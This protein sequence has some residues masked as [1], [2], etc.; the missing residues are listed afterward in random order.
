ML[1]LLTLALTGILFYWIPK[2]FF[3]VQNTGIIQGISEA[4]PK[5]S[6]AAMVKRQQDIVKVI[7]QDP[8]VENVTSF[9]GTDG[10]NTALNRGRIQIML[11]EVNGEYVNSMKVIQRLEEKLKQV[12]G[13]KLY[14][15]PVQDI[16]IEDRISPRQYQYS[17][18][19]HEDKEVSVLSNKLV[20]Q[21]QT[22]PALKDVV[23]D[24]QEDGLQT[25]ITIDRDSA[26]RFGITPQMIDNILYDSFSQR[27]ISTIF[28][29]LNQYHVI[30]ELQ[31]NLQESVNAFDDLYLRSANGD[32]VPINNFIKV[33]QSTRSNV[34]Y[35]QG[36]FPVANLSFN[37]AEKTALGDATHLIEQAEKSINLPLHISTS[38][39]GVAK[40]F[41]SSFAN[42]VWLILASIIIVYIVLGILYES[43]IHPFT[44]LS[45]LPSAGL[46]VLLALILLGHEFNIIALI[47]TILL[48]GIVMKNAIMMID[49]ALE[50]E[51]IQNK[52]AKEAI[53][54]ACLL[55]LRP[56][57]M[58]T[59]SAM[60]GAVPL[61]F[62]AGIGSEIRE[63]LG[64]AIIGGLIL[65]QLLTLYTTPVVYLAF[66]KLAKIMSSS[67]LC[68]RR[69]SDQSSNEEKLL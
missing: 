28:T 58:T 19:G 46:G 33:T 57:L 51:R 44:I 8:A 15:Q 7:L 62:G 23:N 64:I 60:L 63:P 66:D 30:L 10:I 1:G 67:L 50:L 5:I 16:T 43:Y 17:L 32:M 11:K 69:L 18:S 25:T 24:L 2:G 13:T 56:I 47:G 34:I 4:T 68:S 27:Q 29:Q 42:E 53:Y 49:F 41:Q 36:Q 52:P 54:E 31:P 20:H 3:P 48:I 9:I 22:I 6:F 45:T 55:R 35:R 21:L 40:I 12:K 61:A 65:S 26:S 59:M 39:E 38:F 14:M 37:L